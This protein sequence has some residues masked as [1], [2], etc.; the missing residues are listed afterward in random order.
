MS[1]S[2]KIRLKYNKSKHI[3]GI[4]SMPNANYLF[5]NINRYNRYKSDTKEKESNSI[6]NNSKSKQSVK[7]KNNRSFVIKNNNKKESDLNKM[8]TNS[9]ISKIKKSDNQSIYNLKVERK[10]HFMFE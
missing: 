10:N 3:K 4:Y 6:K 2:S 1:E 7:Q 9:T 5:S 8:P